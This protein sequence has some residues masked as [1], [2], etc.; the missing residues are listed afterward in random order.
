MNAFDAEKLVDLAE[1]RHDR[2][3]LEALQLFAAQTNA[4]A[5]IVATLE[6]HPDTD[7]EALGAACPA[8]EQELYN[9]GVM[10]KA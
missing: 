5:R 7:D 3:L 9:C 1:Q 6:H 8:A 10:K 4:N 2:G